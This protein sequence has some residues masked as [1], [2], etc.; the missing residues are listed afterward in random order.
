MYFNKTYTSLLKSHLSLDIIVGYN[1]T[2]TDRQWSLSHEHADV[3][4]C[5]EQSQLYIYISIVNFAQVILKL[6][7]LASQPPD[8]YYKIIFT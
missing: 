2:P 6:Y 4:I 7:P 1:M 3:H 8:V 5:T